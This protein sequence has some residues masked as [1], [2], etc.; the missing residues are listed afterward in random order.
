MIHVVVVEDDHDVGFLMMNLLGRESGIRAVHLAT[1]RAAMEAEVWQFDDE[2]RVVGILD[3]MLSS[4]TTG[5]EVAKWVKGRF[6]HIP[7]IG[8]TALPEMDELY[9]SMKQVCNIVLNK[10]VVPQV[11]IEHIIHMAMD[12]DGNSG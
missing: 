9:V 10:P 7:L 6:P 11:L 2:T 4:D 3:I 1:A 8:L 12:K 5:V